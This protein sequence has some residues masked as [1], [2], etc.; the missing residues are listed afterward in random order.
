MKH[1]VRIALP[2]LSELTADSLMVFAI[3]DRRQ[4]LVRS[5]ELKLDQLAAGLPLPSV[6]AILHPGDAVTVEVDVPPLPD[7]RM[8]AAVESRVEPLALSDLST[9]C[10]AHGARRNDGKVQV[11]WASRRLL[12][13]GWQR[14]VDAGLDVRAL[15][16]FELAIPPDDAQPHTPLS[17]P[18]D[19]RWHAMLPK[20]SLAR[21]DLGPRGEARHWRNAIGWLAAAALV[22]TVGLQLYAAQLRQ[23]VRSLQDHM[24]SKVRSAFPSIPAVLNPLQQARTQVEGLRQG[25]DVRSTDR[26]LPLALEAARLLAFASGHVTGLQYE[27]GQLSIRLAE[28]YRPPADAAAL[29]Q[30]AATAGVRLEKDTDQAHVWH[31]SWM[32]SS[33]QGKRP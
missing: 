33:T 13:D 14:L 20:W 22:W 21:A 10:I 8:Q 6:Y 19:E 26:F 12:L 7:S 15:I 18:V 27:H 32:D 1:H 16:P 28:G 24:E 2:P 17:L 23:E 11:A 25:N 4:R 31:V 9:L 5:G 29:Q 30:A 3:F